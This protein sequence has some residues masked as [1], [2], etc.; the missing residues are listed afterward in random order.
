MIE[1]IIIAGGGTGGHL[2]SGIAVVEEIKRRAPSVEVLYVGTER[3]I[4]ARVVPDM[5]ERLETLDVTPLK[6]KRPLELLRSLTRV[7]FAAAKA[8][9]IVQRLSPDLVLGVGGYASGPMVMAA[10]AMRVPTALIE[11]NAHLGLTNRL[12]APVVGRAYVSFERTARSFGN[13]SRVFG[14]PIRRAFVDAAR[15]ALSDPDGFEARSR[16]VLVL[17]GSQGAR[18]L[19]EQVPAGLAKLDVPVL[20]QTGRASVDAVAKR[21]RELGVDAQVVPF[22]DDMAAAL[23]AASLVIGRAGAS[24]IAELSAIGRPAILVPFPHAADDHQTANA[25]AL[26]DAGAAITMPESQLSPE[27]LAGEPG[28][29]RFDRLETCAEVVEHPFELSSLPKGR[30]QLGEDDFA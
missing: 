12:L 3:G 1:R 5:G 19:N 7:P 25:M 9:G 29:L 26:S 13:R 14:N 17:G 28:G 11:Q 21:Y 23:S 4:E 20:H 10:A 15:L 27:S 30:S 6:G 24:T 22:I 16:R 8:G 18:A 2:F